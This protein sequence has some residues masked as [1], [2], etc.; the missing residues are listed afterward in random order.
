MFPH[1]LTVRRIGGELDARS[2]RTEAVRQFYPF[3]QAACAEVIHPPT[4]AGT[5]PRPERLPRQN[6]IDRRTGHHAAV[7]VHASARPACDQSDGAHVTKQ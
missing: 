4:S 6:I 2:D 5:P 7:L 1:A 3:R